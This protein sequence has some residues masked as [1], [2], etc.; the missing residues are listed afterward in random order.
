MNLHLSDV[1]M[2]VILDVYVTITCVVMFAFSWPPH[3][4]ANAGKQR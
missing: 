1:Q 3:N 2:L 4:L